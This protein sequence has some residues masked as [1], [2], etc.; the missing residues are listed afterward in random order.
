MLCIPAIHMAHDNPI[1][2]ARRGIANILYVNAIAVINHNHI[3]IRQPEDF[4]TS[5]TYTG[6]SLTWYRFFGS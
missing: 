2:Q 3:L 1:S 6:W 4:S 5:C